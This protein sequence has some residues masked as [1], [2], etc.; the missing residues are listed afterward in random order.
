MLILLRR[1]PEKGLAQYA[2]SKHT[3][4]SHHITRTH[5][6]THTLIT[7]VRVDRVVVL[8]QRSREYG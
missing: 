6:R 2:I 4:C 5:A 8:E 3:T 1:G 7:F